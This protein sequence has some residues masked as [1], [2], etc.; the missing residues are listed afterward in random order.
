MR[1]AADPFAAIA[2]HLDAIPREHVPAALARLA[3]RALEG[4]GETIALATVEKWL[5][6][7]DVATRLGVHRKWVYDHKDRLGARKLSHR[8]LRVPESG[9]KRYLKTRV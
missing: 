4:S 3:A 5:T 6:P 1:R 7:D 8:K 2:A 9:L